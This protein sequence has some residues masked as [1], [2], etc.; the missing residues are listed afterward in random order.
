MGLTI[1]EYGTFTFNT[2]INPT[3]AN[4]VPIFNISSI[5]QNEIDLTSTYQGYNLQFKLTGTF[6]SGLISFSNKE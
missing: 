5:S 1:T 6:D 4:N 2:E 3:N